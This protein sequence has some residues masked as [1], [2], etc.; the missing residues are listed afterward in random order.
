MCVFLCAQSLLLFNEWLK[1]A[2]LVF[3]HFCLG[4]GLIDMAMNQAVT[5]VY[6][7]FGMYC[8]KN[9]HYAQFSVKIFKH[10]WLIWALI[11]RYH[12]LRIGLSLSLDPICFQVKITQWTLSD[13]TL[14]EKTLLS[15]QW[16][17]LFTLFSISWSSTDSS[18]TIG[19]NP[20]EGTQLNIVHKQQKM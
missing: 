13:G 14:W 4:R 11:P 16:K 19:K 9:P 15:W 8:T 1:K 6:A 2:L 12:S 20:A 3:P 10:K 7:R 17:D 18:W 5:D